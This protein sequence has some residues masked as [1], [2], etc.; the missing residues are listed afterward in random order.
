MSCV[1]IFL[2]LLCSGGY[3]AV[4]VDLLLI[5]YMQPSL[6]ESLNVDHIHAA[7]ISFAS[8]LPSILGSLLF[9]YLADRIGRRI[10]FIVSSLLSALFGLLSSLASSYWQFVV[11]RSLV[12]L[13]LGGLASVDFVVFN[14]LCPSKVRGK[15]TLVITMFGAL[16]VLSVAGNLF[17]F[18]INIIDGHSG[19]K[20]SER[21]VKMKRF[22]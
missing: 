3:F 13:G 7:L 11:C 16:G 14:E 4:C 21:G 9:G 2:L 15:C 10:P 20:I 1:Q 17:I 5:V 22:L 12:G 18:I 6:E 8:S 19:Y